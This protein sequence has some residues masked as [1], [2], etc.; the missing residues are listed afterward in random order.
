MEIE[1]RP[2]YNV[3]NKPRKS[4]KPKQSR[5]S[6]NLDKE[7]EKEKITNPEIPKQQ[8]PDNQDITSIIKKYNKGKKKYIKQVNK[9]LN[10]LHREL[11]NNL[12]I[13]YFYQS[14]NKNEF[15]DKLNT[16]SLDKFNKELNIIEIEKFTLLYN[17]LKK[18]CKSTHKKTKKHSNKKHSTK[19]Q[20][21]KTKKSL[22]GGNTNSR[23]IN[24]L[25]NKLSNKLNIK[26]GPYLQRLTAKGNKPITGNDLKKALNEI[27][28]ILDK[29]RYI[30][31]GRWVSKPNILL[32]YFLGNNE[33]L[34]EYAKYDLLPKYVNLRTFP[35]NIEFKKIF[36]KFSETGTI[37]SLYNTDKQFRRQ[38][39]IDKGV[40]DPN[41]YI[42]STKFDV[43]AAEIGKL[44]S[45]FK[46]LGRMR[47]LGRRGTFV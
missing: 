20:F 19:K 32:N 33:E 22:K 17:I 44:D 41:K 26:G 14:K 24:K 37:I 7:K 31:E 16:Y 13:I 43:Y 28:E 5:K 40:K 35:P 25:S 45:K 10:E 29:L 3:F 15:I 9:N 2:V 23:H 27:T 36:N 46:E 34:E 6:I 11:I 12:I 42:K 39:L 30:E 38:Y 47:M 18:Q 4:N 21:T 8:L 1:N